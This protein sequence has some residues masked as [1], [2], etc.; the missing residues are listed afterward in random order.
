MTPMSKTSTPSATVTVRDSKG[1]KFLE[2]VSAAYNKA[3]LT[4]DEAQ[5]VNRAPGLADLIARHI[6]QHRHEVPPIL[7]L[8]ANGIQ[9][10]SAKRFVAKEHFTQ[11]N[12]FYP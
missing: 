4:E 7:K 12:G 1:L 6:S 8:V 3:G 11:E 9:V 5:R 10:A 2:V